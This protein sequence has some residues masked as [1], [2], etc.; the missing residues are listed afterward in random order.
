MI[1]TQLQTILKLELGVKI[2]S[3]LVFG[4]LQTKKIKLK[5]IANDFE[6]TARR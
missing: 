3:M 6:S 5:T 1:K 2:D 4:E